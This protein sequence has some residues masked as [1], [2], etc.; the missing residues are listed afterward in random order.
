MNKKVKM[1]CEGAV[2]IALAVALSY[3]DIPLGF[4]GGSINLTMIPIV[5]FALRYGCLEG[6]I[7]GF[8]FGTLKFFF[9]GG[10]A[11]NWQSMLLDYSVAYAAVGVAGLFRNVKNG[12][13]IGTVVGGFLRFVVH[14]I[15]G[16]TIYAEYAESTYLGINTANM[17]IY[18][19]VYNAVYML[20]SIIICVILVPIIYRILEKRLKK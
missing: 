20:P 18:S 12:D 16:V 15:S 2:M 17:Y 9:A 13:I 14:F 8:I 11:L 5:I 1:L 7:A 19:A 3:V 10:A 4:Q 6:V